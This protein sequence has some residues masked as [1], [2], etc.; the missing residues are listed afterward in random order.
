MLPA[1]GSCPVR[2]HCTIAVVIP[3]HNEA[4]QIE[5]VLGTMPSYV[6]FIVV[7]DDASDDDTAA[8]VEQVAARDSRVVLVRNEKN[9]GCGGSVAQGY[10]VALERDADVIAVMDADGQMPADELAT[11]VDPVATGKCDYAKANRLASSD[12]W[13]VIPRSRYLG[14]AVLTAL[15]KVSSGYYHVVDSQ[16]G[17]AAVSARALR[18]ID[19][20][21]LYPRYGYPNDLLVLL[22]VAR[23]RVMSVPTRAVYNVGERS[24]MRIPH[25]VGPLSRLLIRRFW[26]RMIVGNAIRDFH[27]VVL[28][29]A[30]GSAA[31]TV[32]MTYSGYLVWRAIEGYHPT[33]GDAALSLF[34]LGSGLILLLFAMLFDF[35]NGR[36]LAVT[37]G[38]SAA[39]SDTITVHHVCDSCVKTQVSEVD[40]EELATLAFTTDRNE[41]TRYV[42]K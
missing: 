42:V 15:T 5:G 12:A 14:N 31:V 26:W 39:R 19:L 16:S 7:V 35:E 3:A 6:D 18:R 30:I 40:I 9:L 33:T 25:V 11:L 10:R 2:H 17:F 23:A 27:P 41:S 34:G 36:S 24:G 37:E 38:N 22:N 4:H 13:Q 20:D 32:G 29:Y 28:F 8:V 21:D 1:K